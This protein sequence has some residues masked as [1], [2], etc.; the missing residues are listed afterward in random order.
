[1]FDKLLVLSEGRSIFLGQER[2]AMG[3]FGSRGFTPNI[4]MNPIDFLLDLATR[5]IFRIPT[6][7]KPCITIGNQAPK[8]I[9]NISIKLIWSLKKEL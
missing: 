2:D 6:P 1:M 7:L 4:P 5:D 8:E 9:Q 3:Y